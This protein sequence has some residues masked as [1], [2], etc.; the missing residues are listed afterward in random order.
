MNTKH[1]INEEYK[2]EEWKPIPDFNHYLISSKG[3][4][5]NTRTGMIK[6]SCHDYKGYMRIRLIDGRDRG[7][8][9]KIH[10]LVAQ[11]F[12]SNYSDNLQVNHKNCIK[13][14][15]RLENLEMVTQSQ[16]TQHA[17]NNGRMKL[18]SRNDKGVFVTNKI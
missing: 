10:R 11:A 5:Y 15:N 12:L 17:W 2:S 4:V 8:T 16:N 6:K 14:D 7:S 1:A 18:T 3:L 9:K 13:D